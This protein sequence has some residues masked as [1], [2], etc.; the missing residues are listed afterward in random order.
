MITDE[1]R[2]LEDFEKNRAYFRLPADIKPC[3]AKLIENQGNNHHKGPI[4]FIIACEL[5]RTGGEPEA[6]RNTLESLS[7][8]ES[9]IRGIVKS[10]ESKDYS[11]G[12]PSL[13]AMGLCLF[14]HREECFWYQRIPRK[15]TKKYKESDFWQYGWPNLLSLAEI[16]V[17]LAIRETERIRRCPAGSRLYVSRKQ[18]S[19]FTGISPP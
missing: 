12:C 2:K 16:V 17:Y 18:L 4:P 11:Y 1:L 3:I 13:E 15:N 9:K 19:R 8:K 10:L 14:K 6:I 5:R 7:V